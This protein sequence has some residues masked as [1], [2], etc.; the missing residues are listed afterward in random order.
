MSIELR[1]IH[2]RF[3]REVLGV[4]LWELFDP[5]QNDSRNDGHNR[6]IVEGIREAFN[7]HPLLVFRRQCLT[8]DDLLALGHSLGKPAEY[9]ERSWHS[10]RPEVSIVSNKPQ[11]TLTTSI[12]T[13]GSLAISCFGITR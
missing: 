6:G 12:I 3:A 2:G 1:T 4:N 9:I 13:T 10:S 8:D 11:H 5:A 7:E